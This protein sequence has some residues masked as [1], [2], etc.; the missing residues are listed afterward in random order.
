MNHSQPLW[1]PSQDLI[2]K[3]NMTRFIAEVNSRYDRS[4]RRETRT[5][6]EGKV[7]RHSGQQWTRWPER[8]GKVPALT[9]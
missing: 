1:Q 8:R 7:K 4:P 9:E 2:D 3:A 5:G 6:V